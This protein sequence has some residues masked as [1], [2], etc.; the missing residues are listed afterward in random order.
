MDNCMFQIETALLD[1]QEMVGA[2][3]KTSVVKW[4]AQTH[5]FVFDTELCIR[6]MHF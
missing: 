5:H 6:K 4:Y 2:E 1:F 3:D